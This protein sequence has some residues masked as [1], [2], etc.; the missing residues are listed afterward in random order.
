[1]IAF[2]IAVEEFEFDLVQHRAFDEIFGAEAVVDDRSAAQAAH[3]RGHG[4]A[5][6]AR[7]AMV[8]A[9]NGVKITLVHDNHSRT[10]LRRFQHRSLLG[11]AD[12]AAG[13]NSRRVSRA[14]PKARG[15]IVRVRL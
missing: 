13:E 15:A 3:A 14:A 7:R 10:Q 11:P 6:V 5:L 12:R 1:M 2:A 8:H 9:V 4:A